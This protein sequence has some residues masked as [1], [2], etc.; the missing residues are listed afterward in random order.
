MKE[1][2]LS[3]CLGWTPEPQVTQPACTRV[4]TLTLRGQAQPLLHE[5][6]HRGQTQLSLA[7]SPVNRTQHHGEVQPQ[8]KDISFLF[9]VPIKFLQKKTH[10]QLQVFGLSF[11]LLSTKSQAV[12][13]FLL[14]G[15][16]LKLNVPEVSTRC[17]QNHSKVTGE[18]G[19][20]W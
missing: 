13:E 10:L 7:V 8:Y 15:G 6:L 14:E 16:E 9:L 5:H 4:Q 20:L 11:V 19:S 2:L 18:L 1:R 12:A 3:R 17:W